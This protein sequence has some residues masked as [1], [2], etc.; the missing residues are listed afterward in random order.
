MANV[1][2]EGCMAPKTVIESLRSYIADIIIF[3]IF[4]GTQSESSRL[5]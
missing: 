3:I 2:D 4:L 1:V 5:V